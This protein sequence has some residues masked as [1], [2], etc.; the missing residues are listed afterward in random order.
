MCSW[1]GDNVDYWGN[2]TGNSWRTTGDIGDNWGSMLSNWDHNGPS[3]SASPGGWNDPDMLEVGNGG[4]TTTEYITHFSLWCIGK[5]PLLIGCDITKMSADTQMIL[6]NEEAIAINQDKYGIQ[7]TRKTNT[8][9]GNYQVYSTPLSNNQVA[10]LFLNRASSSGTIEVTW[11]ELGLQSTQTYV[12]RDLWKK[13]NVATRAG[14]YSTSVA[15]HGV[16]F[17]KFTPSN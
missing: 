2:N 8:N 5:A 16:A 14:N 17:L 10:V 11:Q 13:Q 6:M 15:S 3:A 12:I 7:A 1:G 9:G 4:M